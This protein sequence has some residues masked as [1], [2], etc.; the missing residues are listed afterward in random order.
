MGVGVLASVLTTREIA[1]FGHREPSREEIACRAHELYL[2][3]G[4]EQ[5]KDVEDWVT[6]EKELSDEPVG[7]SENE[8]L[9]IKDIVLT[10]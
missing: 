5:G 4:S 3:R 8:R 9:T 2:Q 6:A 7:T 10:L 1:V